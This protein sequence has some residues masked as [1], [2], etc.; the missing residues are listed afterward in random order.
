MEKT[1]QF[2]RRCNEIRNSIQES[3][4]DIMELS[5]H[6]VFL[7]LPDRI[8]QHAEVKANIQLAFRHIEDARMRL[9]KVIQAASSG[10]SCYESPAFAVSCC[11]NCN[12][13]TP[14]TDKES[15]LNCSKMLIEVLPNMC[16]PHHVWDQET[17]EK[18]KAHNEV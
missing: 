7:Q 10:E 6:D 15:T 13:A 12:H 16:C 5:R 17:L 2:K 3:G 4:D 14:N 11:G 8:G 9:G 18:V 1:E